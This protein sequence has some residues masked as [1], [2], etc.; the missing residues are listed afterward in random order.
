MK[1]F[2]EPGAS[3][4]LSNFAPNDTGHAERPCDEAK[5]HGGKVLTGIAREHRRRLPAITDIGSCAKASEGLSLA[6]NTVASG[7]RRG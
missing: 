7:A 2:A 1:S 3:C 5:E 4:E 6:C